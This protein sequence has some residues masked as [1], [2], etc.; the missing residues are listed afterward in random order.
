MRYNCL[1]LLA[2][3]HGLE[4]LSY[5]AANT[6]LYNV[7]AVFTHRLNP[8]SQDPLQ[9]ERKDYVDFLKIAQDAGM[10]V[11]TI[12]SKADKIRLEE[13][14]K[15]NEY[16]FLV[17]VSWRHLIPPS[18]FQKARLGAINIHRGDLPKYA[19]AE[20]IK[21]ALQN[22]EKE[23]YI[24]SHHI[25]ENYDEGKVICKASHPVNYDASKTL[26]E[27]VVRL[28]KEISPHFTQLLIESFSIL[29][30]EWSGKA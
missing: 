28:K 27:N 17:S 29:F 7:V 13:F 4:V 9:G 14:A 30:K 18:V 8:K 24:C 26:E 16:D 3:N 19:G 25:T 23:I 1:A 11:Y 2:R 15:N 21:K 20:P 22:G 12:D 10:P 5:L 6:S